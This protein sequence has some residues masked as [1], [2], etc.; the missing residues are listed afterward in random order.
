MKPLADRISTK[1]RFI[2]RD[3]V[4]LYTDDWRVMV[5][6]M[7]KIEPV[8]VYDMTDMIEVE[9]FDEKCD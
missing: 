3:A 8:A 5:D 1:P 2:L 4:K 7:D 9:F 6:M